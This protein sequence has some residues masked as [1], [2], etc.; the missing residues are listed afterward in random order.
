M[1]PDVDNF[2]SNA[3]NWQKE[4][5]QLRDILL[6][7]GLTEEF[8][9]K[10]PVYTWL[11]KNV[12]GINGVKEYCALAFFKG[13]LLLD[14]DDLLSKP[15]DNT[16]APRWIKFT[17]VRD[18]TRLRNVLKA[19]IYEA[20][21]VE[22]A[23]VKLPT[24]KP[25]P[26]PAE[27][28]KKFKK[29]AALKKAFFSLTAGRQRAYL[30][31]FSQPKQSKTRESRIDKFT[32]QILKGKCINDDYNAARK[33]RGAGNHFIV[34]LLLVSLL[35]F[36]CGHR[37]GAMTEQ[38]RANISDSVLL[39]TTNIARDLS[40]NGPAVWLKYFDDAP[41]FFMIDDGNLSFPDYN[42]ARRFILDT[43]VKNIPHITLNWSA[44]RV[45][46]LSRHLASIDAQ[47]HE[48]L[49][50][51]NGAN[52]PIQGYLSATAVLTNHGWKLHNLHWSTRKQM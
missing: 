5:Q 1:N 32:P 16:Q 14:T 39:L 41:G 28:E 2:L 27:L 26:I 24:R 12:I 40:A 23:G 20:I 49:M 13:A 35:A 34:G 50:P 25:L 29:N 43:L 45:F 38:D 51:A 44:V 3:D 52:I 37:R 10:I 42:S 31:H 8:K 48:V 30:L 17:S 46:P 33:N 22:K 15:G 9:W 6:G 19:Y 47:F 18:I 36:S 11:G 4:M 21:E 7:C